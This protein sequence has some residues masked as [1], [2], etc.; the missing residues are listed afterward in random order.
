MATFGAMFF[1]LIFQLS[2]GCLIGAIILRAAFATYKWIA[3]LVSGSP[4]TAPAPQETSSV[5]VPDTTAQD[6]IPGDPSNPYAAP[7]VTSLSHTGTG[8]IIEPGF[9]QAYVTCLL[10]GVAN[11]VVGFGMAVLGTMTQTVIIMFVSLII[12]ALVPLFVIKYRHRLTFLQ[13]FGIVVIMFV[14]IMAIALVIGAIV[15]ATGMF[16]A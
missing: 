9:G 8:G 11:I 6:F 12:N 10:I 2:F 15:S 13:A 4:A 14:I 3:R 16:Q 5:N 7:T 1:V